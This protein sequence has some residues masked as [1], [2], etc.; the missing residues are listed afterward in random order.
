MD[1]QP[2]SQMKKLRL[3]KLPSVTQPGDICALSPVL[4][5]SRAPFF[6]SSNSDDKS[7][8]SNLANTHT[9]LPMCRTPPKAIGAC[10][11][12]WQSM[13]MLTLPATVCSS[14]FQ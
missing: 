6:T 14:Y 2:F 8:D 13:V 4:P 5:G 11:K 10:S 3:D 7:N 1:C 12:C 9:T